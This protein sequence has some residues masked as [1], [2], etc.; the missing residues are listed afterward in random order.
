MPLTICLIGKYFPIQGGVSKD[1]V[2]LSYHLAKAGF[3]VHVVTN[4]EEVEPQYRSLPWS[5]PPLLPPGCTGS[6]TVHT[7]Q[8]QERRHY[9]PYANPFVSKLASIA[10]EVVRTHRCDL[11]YS[12]YLE[13]YAVAA[14]LVSRWTRVPYG[15]RH[16][17]SDVG[18]LLQSPEL[19]TTYQEV[20][21]GADYIVATSSTF[22]RFLH[23]GVPL[24]PRIAQRVVT[25]S[26]S[27]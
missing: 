26:P 5:P 23:L 19:Q 7:T 4:A 11:I 20:V 21:R 10:T 24:D 16:A 25:G 27:A 6:I 1:N 12:Y 14:A 17:G 3:H 15:V 22:R 18:A 8:L 9:I 2:W 13:P